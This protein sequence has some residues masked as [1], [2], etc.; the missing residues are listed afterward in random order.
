MK[1]FLI[2]GTIGAVLLQ[3]ATDTVQLNN[4][5]W[6]VYQTRLLPFL[7]T[8][9]LYWYL[10]LF[11]LTCV[12]PMSFERRI[13][14]YKYWKALFP[15]LLIVAVV[16]LAWDSYKT[17]VGVWGFNPEHY[18]FLLGN[19]PIEE[20]FFFITFPFA[21]IFIY[22]SLNYYFPNDP[23]AR[24]EPYVTPALIGLFLV[25]GFAYWSHAYTSTTFIVCGGFLLYHYWFI[26]PHYRGRFY[27]GLLVGY[28]PFIIVNGALTGTF[29]ERPV[30]VYNP[31]E[32]LGIRI[33]SIPLDDFAY[34]F[35]LEFSVITLYEFFKIKMGLVR[36]AKAT[37]A[38]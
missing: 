29:T 31:E 21:S 2:V 32:Y 18:T 13:H 22:E 25:V 33:L 8:R 12:L 19:L 28:I 38:L 7:E 34:N 30:V 26:D 5:V 35:I 24:L 11:A 37:E 1:I 16:F 3:W 27:N 36:T 17:Y 6:E 23:F 20:W 14:Y 9:Y 15:A 4:F 10:H